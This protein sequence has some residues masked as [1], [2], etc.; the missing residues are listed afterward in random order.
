MM[1]LIDSIAEMGHTG[2]R[3]WGHRLEVINFERFSRSQW[4]TSRGFTLSKCGMFPMVGNPRLAAT[5]DGVILQNGKICGV[6]ESKAVGY[7]INCKNLAELCEM[8]KDCF[9]SLENGKL[10]IDRSHEY[11]YQMQMQMAVLEVDMCVC[12]VSTGKNGEIWDIMEVSFHK[13]FWDSCYTA[14]CNVL[15]SVRLYENLP[16]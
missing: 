14:I 11:Y 15:E 16:L 10:L 3:A 5:P 12:V 2:A 9:V 6:F 1:K 13:E 8:K 7:E 4:L